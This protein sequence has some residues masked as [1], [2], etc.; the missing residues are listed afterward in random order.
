MMKPW[1]LRSP[2][3]GGHI[4]ET[5]GGG[6]DFPGKAEERPLSARNSR[7]LRRDGSFEGEC[8][9]VEPT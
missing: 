3:A 9:N 5:L 4:L 7:K 6:K 2:E 1:D 8:G